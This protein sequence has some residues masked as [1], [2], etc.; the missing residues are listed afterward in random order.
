[1]KTMVYPDTTL[2]ICSALCGPLL[3]TNPDPFFTEIMC[4]L[5]KVFV[6]NLANQRL[7]RSIQ[8]DSINKP[9]RAIPSRRMTP[10]QAQR[11]LLACLPLVLL[12]DYLALGA[13]EEAVV[14]MVAT[15]MYND[16]GGADES[17]VVRN[18]SNA[19][20]IVLYGSG[21]IRVA[22]GAPTYSLNQTAY[23]WLATIGAVA[24][25]TVQLQDLPDQEG[26]KTRDRKT[27]PLAV[28]DHN[29]RWATAVMVVGRSLTCPVFWRLELLGFLFPGVLGALM[30]YRT[31]SKR[32]VE[33]DK[34][35]FKLWCLWMAILYVL[36]LFALPKGWYMGTSASE[37]F[38]LLG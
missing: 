37:Q 24:F 13:V 3:T 31:L 15:W 4:R 22:C 19:L 35:T 12:A 32:T 5:P 38:T 25:S 9:W 7:P 21:S 6:F 30:A 1:M 20:G 34:E 36:P 14:L 17:F 26:D 27:M 28:G 18:L 10:P 23:Q 33:A 11:L 8:E 2:G 16:L 29:A